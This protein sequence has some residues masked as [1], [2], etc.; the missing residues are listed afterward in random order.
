MDT[1]GSEG[2]ILRGAEQT[3]KTYKPKLWISIHPEF[4][5]L[6]YGEYSRDVRSWIINL[7]YEETLLEY[8]HELHAMYL[9]KAVV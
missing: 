8:E 7:G 9:L 5:A 3:L 6:N 2:R 1:E 4:L